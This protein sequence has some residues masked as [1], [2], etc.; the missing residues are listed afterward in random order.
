MSLR[1]T[2]FTLMLLTGAV[3]GNLALA[4]DHR[5]ADYTMLHPMSDIGDSF[6]FKGAQ[7]GGLVMSYTLNPLSGSGS[8]GTL[9]SDEIKLD[10]KL[11]YMFKLDTDN[12][13]IADIVY[14]VK[15]ADIDGEAQRQSVIMRRAT[16]K[17]AHSN[18]F[19]GEEVGRGFTTALN[20]ALEVTKGDNGELLFVGPRRDPFFFDFSTVQAPAALAIEQ[21]LAGG[22]NLPAAPTSLGAFGISDMTLITLEVPELADQ[23]LNYWV[24][25]SEDDGHVVDRMGRAG[26]QGIFFVAP[27]VGYNPA[28]YLPVDKQYKTIGIFNDAYN[29]SNPDEGLS[30]FGDQFKFS[31]ERLEVKA[32]EL[33]DKV[34]FYAPDMLRW[35]PSQPAG[36]PNG[37]S[38]AEDAIYWTIKDVNPFAYEAPDA[39]L[40]RSSDQDLNLSKF[41]YAA[42]SFNQA[43]KPGIPVRPVAPIYMD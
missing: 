29:A 41:P 24:M 20:T 12:D 7:T 1:Y 18:R 14:K 43:W 31:F 28:R 15:V 16:G 38:Y 39:F 17:D 26:V 9:G 10:P 6:L 2:I 4:S 13:A 36:Y 8:P 37:R 42:P 27:P 25:V 34:D 19:D 3:I 5:D 21:A 40:P 33:K 35:D 23:A 22:D 32:D 30:K 11:I